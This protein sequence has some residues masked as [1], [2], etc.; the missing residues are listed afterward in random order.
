MAFTESVTQQEGKMMSVME[1]I[2]ARRSIRSYKDQPVEEE[3]LRTILEAGRL[4]PSANNA[5]DWKFVVVRDA[6]TRQKLIQAAK[7]QAFVGEAPVVIAACGTAPTRVMSCGHQSCPVD[8]AIAVDHMSLA[9][10][11]LG[12]GC[13]WVCAFDQEAA[14]EVLGI[15][16]SV[17]VVTLLPLGYAAAPG[18]NPRRKD[19]D[20]VVVFDK[21]P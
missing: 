1:T 15:P 3:K 20:E 17:S 16:D 18:G 11:E 9:A 7:N 5:Q 21:W 4:A 2:K 6:A 14:R 13:C 10:T 8:L 19:F 12:L